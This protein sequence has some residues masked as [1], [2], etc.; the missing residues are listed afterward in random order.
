MIKRAGEVR[1]AIT[2][3]SGDVSRSREGGNRYRPGRRVLARSAAAQLAGTV[4]V[5][6][7]R[8]V[9]VICQHIDRIR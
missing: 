7:L 9:E 4:A 5:H 1:A 2:A 3:A 8:A 6:N